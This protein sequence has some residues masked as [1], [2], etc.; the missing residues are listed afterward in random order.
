MTCI[1]DPFGFHPIWT[2]ANLRP[3]EAAREEEKQGLPVSA[4]PWEWCSSQVLLY[5]WPQQLFLAKEINSTKDSLE[6]SP[7]CFCIT[8]S[9]LT[10]PP[11]SPPQCPP[12][13]AKPQDVHRQPQPLWSARCQSIPAKDDQSPGASIVGQWVSSKGQSFSIGLKILVL[14]IL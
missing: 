1:K 3:T 14:E 9:L 10:P 8:E 4:R 5:R 7:K 2:P 11:A 13:P 6:I 12:T